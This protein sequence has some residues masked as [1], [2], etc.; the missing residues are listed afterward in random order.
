MTM[1]S[2]RDFLENTAKTGVV[3]GSAGLLAACGGSSSSASSSSS[4][5]QG[6]PKRG[7]TL[8]MGV[9]GGSSADTFDPNLAATNPAYAGMIV[10]YEAL[11]WYGNA[12]VTVT[13]RLA[14]ELTPNKDA[15]VWTI[16]LRPGV[17]FHNGKPLTAD[18]VIFSIN[19]AINPKAP[20]PAANFLPG[21]IASGMK[22]L[23]NLTL[24]IPFSRP[25]SVLPEFIASSAG[26]FILPVGFDP[27]HPIGTGPFKYVSFEPGQQA[28][29]ARNEN[30]WNQPLPYLDTLIITNYLDETT[31]VD[32]L[33]SGQED[34]VSP[35][36]SVSLGAV[37]G[38]GK[39]VLISP[40]GGFN[41][42]TMR[43]DV[44][45]FD[46]V[47]VRQAFKLVTDRQ[48]MLNTVFGGHG[49]IGNDIFGIW[50]ADYDH[51]IPQRPHDPEQAKSLLKAAGHDGLNV[52]LVT[53]DAAQGVIQMTEV[54]AQQA[55]AAG[56]KVKLNQ[57]TPTVLFGPNF[58]QWSFAV[59]NWNYNPYLPNV[60]IETLANAPYSETHFDNP[61]YQSLYSEAVSTLDVQKRT[62]LAHE[63][64]M[65]D[66][67][68]GGLI[69]PLFPPVIDAYAQTV[70]GD[71]RSK[72]GASVNLWD[73]EHLWFS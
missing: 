55:A 30:Y 25:F 70:N 41:D 66:Y 47:R 54:Y 64:Q 24:R 46:D 29:F 22:A 65:I 40:G 62:E 67:T 72:T 37:T 51:S 59:N 4:T 45:P 33:L 56:I 26:P 16:R 3:L 44:A 42:I 34:V 38:G 11:T 48:A 6:P 27:K 35:L 28:V 19:R 73:F 9:T 13:N 17:T 8:H 7:G 20:G 5:P 71:V 23:D 60:A 21:I 52:V 50:S 61:R 57:T 15:T 32:A 58:K 68:D 10:M 18:D 14:E 2:R 69:I 53:A 39:R 12:D 43:V 31:Q 49:T 36:S 1:I 63:M